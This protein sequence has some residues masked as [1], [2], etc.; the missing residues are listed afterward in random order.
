MDRL[1]RFYGK[2]VTVDGVVGTFVHHDTPHNIWDARLPDSHVRFASPDG[3]NIRTLVVSGRALRPAADD[4]PHGN[5]SFTFQ[6]PNAGLVGTVEIYERPG[7]C[8][9]GLERPLQDRVYAL[10]NYALYDARVK[11]PLFPQQSL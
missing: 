10:L 6:N 5:R 4:V 11:V 1:S 9:P 8:P 7:F 3:K 2:Q